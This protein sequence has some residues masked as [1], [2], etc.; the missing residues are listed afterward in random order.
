MNSDLRNPWH[1]IN[2]WRELCYDA[3]HPLTWIRNVLANV[4]QVPSEQR[5]VGWAVVGMGLLTVVLG[6]VIVVAA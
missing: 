6:L 4:N 3:R 1:G 5:A 2:A